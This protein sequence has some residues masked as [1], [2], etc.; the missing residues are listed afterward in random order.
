[1]IR[2]Q[3]CILIK[4]D[5]VERK[6]IGKIIARF[7][8]EGFDIVGMKLVRLTKTLLDTWYAH[9]KDKPFF[10]DVCKFMMETPVVALVLNGENIVNRVRDVIGPT[11]STKAPKGTIRGDWGE[12]VQKNLIH[13]SDAPE[14]AEFEINLLFK[15]EEIF[16]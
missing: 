9:H 5:G 6:L 4:P 7:E 14:R 11:D 3:T 10:P 16:G 1:M 2:E 12:S 13:A 8:A 15:K